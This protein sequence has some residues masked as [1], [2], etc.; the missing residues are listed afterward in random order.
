MARGDGAAARPTPA[1]GFKRTAL[2]AASGFLLLAVAGGC[3][4]MTFLVRPS[5]RSGTV[6]RV[7]VTVDP[8]NLGTSKTETSLDVHAGARYDFYLTVRAKDRADGDYASFDIEAHRESTS[9]YLT[10]G[11]IYFGDDQYRRRSRGRDGDREEVYELARNIQVSNQ[12]ESLRM[13]VT[14]SSAWFAGMKPIRMVVDVVEVTAADRLLLVTTSVMQ[15][16][17]FPASFAGL[18]LLWLAGMRQ[19]RLI[20]VPLAPPGRFRLRRPLPEGEGG[21][22]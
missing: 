14:P 10:Y 22:A 7:P 11:Y 19:L 13:V 20:G 3:L 5:P 4:A 17:V 15:V 9:R 16:S 12:D 2:L 18:A 21:G 1:G 6:A 8:N